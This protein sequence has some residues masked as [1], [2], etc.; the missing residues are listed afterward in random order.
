MVRCAAFDGGIKICRSV[1]P[2]FLCSAG[3]LD[4]RAILLAVMG[5][6]ENAGNRICN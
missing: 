5:L 1:P 4:H 2:D 6:T 3:F